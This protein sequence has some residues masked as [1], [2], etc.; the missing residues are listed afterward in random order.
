[1]QLPQLLNGTIPAAPRKAAQAESALCICLLAQRLLQG[2]WLRL[3]NCSTTCSSQV[4]VIACDTCSRQQM[5][6][7]THLLEQPNQPLHLKRAFLSSRHLPGI[8][9]AAAAR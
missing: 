7:Q 8:G 3:P 5:V 1:M 9:F 4:T 6:P 2:C